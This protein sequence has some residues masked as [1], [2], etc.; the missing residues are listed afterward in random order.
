[1]EHRE[2]ISN[3]ELR[4]EDLKTRRQESESRIQDEK[5]KSKYLFSTNYCLLSTEFSVSFC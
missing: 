3:C 4:I 1:M 5:S 2:V